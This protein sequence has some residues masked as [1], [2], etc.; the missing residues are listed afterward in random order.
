MRF[1]APTRAIGYH[2]AEEI[3]P[4]DDRRESQAPPT[5]D[6]CP[7]PLDAPSEGPPRRLQTPKTGGKQRLRAQV[8]ST[9]VMGRWS[10]RGGGGHRADGGIS[11]AGQLRVDPIDLHMSSNHMDMHHADLQAA[12]SAAN[13]DIEA[14]QAGWVGTSAAALQAMFT[15][16]QAASIAL[17]RDVAAHGAAFRAAA[18]GYTTVD[19]DSAGTLD[20]RL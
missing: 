11:M 1:G 13:A 14:A 5:G 16:W 19:A 9:S 10:C 2:I 7:P 6:V 15:Q 20:N 17:C 18:Q 3:R 12:H 4:D 8:T